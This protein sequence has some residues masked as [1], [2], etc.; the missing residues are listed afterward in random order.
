MT[1]RW[2]TGLTRHLVRH[3]LD[4]PALISSAWVVRRNG[5]WRTKPFLPV[6]DESYWEF[7]HKTAMG[8][9]NEPLSVHEVVLAARWSRRERRR[10]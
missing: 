8:E 1:K 10:R 9:S 4:A 5:W 3:P 2:P 6:P 7:R